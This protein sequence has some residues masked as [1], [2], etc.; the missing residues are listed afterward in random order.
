MIHA[1][2]ACPTICESK[3]LTCGACVVHAVSKIPDRL[4]EPPEA[5]QMF[6]ILYPSKGCFSMRY[7]F[8]R[9]L[10]TRMNRVIKTQR[11]G[12]AA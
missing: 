1:E 9:L 11:S 3:G 5:K 8:V 6:A 4:I 12:R 2:D 10:T 7:S